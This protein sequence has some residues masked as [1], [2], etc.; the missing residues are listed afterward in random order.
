MAEALLADV[1]LLFCGLPVGVTASC[2]MALGQSP[3]AFIMAAITTVIGQALF[4]DYRRDASVTTQLIATAMNAM[5]EEDGDA[6]AEAPAANR[7]GSL[8]QLGE[9]L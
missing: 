7:G 9:T 2:F 8:L 5:T 3:Q 1:L 4:A 6:H